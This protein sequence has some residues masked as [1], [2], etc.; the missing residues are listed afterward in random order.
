M[1]R[2]EFTYQVLWNYVIHC[3]IENELELDYVDRV[4]PSGGA[5]EQIMETTKVPM[6][7]SS[8]RAVF[9]K[10]MLMQPSPRCLSDKDEFD[11]Y[12]ENVEMALDRSFLK[13]E[14]GSVCMDD[15]VYVHLALLTREE[16]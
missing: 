6:K 13:L 10:R 9:S 14:V 12:A 8:I 16:E 11:L 7:L 15:A 1:K 3:G 2:S 4:L 5:L